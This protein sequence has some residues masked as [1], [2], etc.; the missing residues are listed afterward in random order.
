[1]VFTYSYNDPT[2]SVSSTVVGNNFGGTV[3]VS[4]STTHLNPTTSTINFAPWAFSTAPSGVSCIAQTWGS[5]LAPYTI[6][7]NT[8]SVEFGFG[9]TIAGGKYDYNCLPR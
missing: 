6:A 5:N 7:E 4:A 2:E 3:T 1:V 8:T 9:S